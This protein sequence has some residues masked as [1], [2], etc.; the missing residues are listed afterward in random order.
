MSI[1]HSLFVTVGGGYEQ[2]HRRVDDRRGRRG[3]Q[4]RLRYE[5]RP[6]R[7]RT[8]CGRP[9]RRHTPSS[10][11]AACWDSSLKAATD[12]ITLEVNGF[13]GRREE[14][15]ISTGVHDTDNITITGSSFK[16]LGVGLGSG[17]GSLMIGTTKPRG[18][19][20]PRRVGQHE[21]VH[22]LWA[23]IPSRTSPR[24]AL[25]SNRTTHRRR[26]AFGRRLGMVLIPSRARAGMRP[27]LRIW[28]RKSRVLRRLQNK[29]GLHECVLLV[30]V[31]LPVDVPAPTRASMQQRLVMYRVGGMRGVGNSIEARR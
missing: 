10:S 19:H 23:A 11:R 5:H 1:G 12:N 15:G 18:L 20:D 9:D 29:R 25:F 22:R 27:P 8:A 14:P 7:L 2:H 30:A 26:F 16:E 4:S 6:A 13:A 17:S 21:L 24:S 3:D 28:S 31:L